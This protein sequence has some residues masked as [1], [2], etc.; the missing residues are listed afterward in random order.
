MKLNKNQLKFF[1]EAVQHF[2]D[3]SNNIRLKDINKFAIENNLIVPT[4]ALKSYCHEQNQKRGYYNLLLS[5][6]E[7]NPP[8]KLKDFKSSSNVI[9]DVPFFV[10]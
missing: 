10:K 3:E 1:I 8:P 5:G 4:S 7:Y 6:V 9:I 2:G